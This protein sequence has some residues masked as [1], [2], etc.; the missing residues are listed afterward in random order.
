[1]HPSVLLLVNSSGLIQSDQY[2]KT[3]ARTASAAMHVKLSI[4][5]DAQACTALRS[6]WGIDVKTL[7]LTVAVTQESQSQDS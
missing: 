5:S 7:L 2:I 1:M 3:G 6:R 4:R